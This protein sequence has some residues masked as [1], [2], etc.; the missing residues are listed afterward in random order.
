M[1]HNLIRILPEKVAS[2]IAAGEVVERPASVLKELIDNS[3]DAR[4]DRITIRIETGGKKLIRVT[5]NGSGMSRDDLLLCVERHATS[6]ITALADLSSVS[7]LGFRGE[8]LPSLAAVSRMEI[9]TR[10]SD[11]LVAYRLNIV[12]GKLNSIDETGAPPGT[13]VSVR[14]LFFNIPAR[15]KFLRTIQTE[16]DRIVDT[17]ARV[18]LPFLGIYFKADQS[19]KTLMNLPNTENQRDRLVVLFGRPVASAMLET[20][21]ESNGFRAKAYLAPP[22]LTRSRGDRLFCYVNQRPIRDKLLIAAIM[23]GYGQRLMRGN[24]PQVVLLL[25]MDPALVDINVHPTKQ[26][27]R[28]HQARPLY[29][30]ISA[31]IARA[32]GEP[33]RAVPSAEPY[34]SGGPAEMKGSAPMLGEPAWNRGGW[35][36]SSDEAWAPNAPS[37]ARLFEDRPEVIGQL[38]R[39]Y[40]LCQNA[41]GL[42]LIDQHAAHERIVFESLKK[43]YESRRIER[44]AFL[45][46][47]KLELSVK[48]GRILAT[49]LDELAELGLEIEPFGGST[50][51]IRSAPSCLSQAEWEALLNEVIALLQEESQLTSA[52]GVEEVLTIMACHGALRAGQAL[53]RT[54]MVSLL[55]QLEEMNLPTHCPHGRP[56]LKK[57]SDYDL[58]RMFK[59]AM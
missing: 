10:P 47:P 5:D 49:K 12:G 13:T 59:R 45:I 54:E 30:G 6:K 29:Q 7:S 2:Q 11:Q 19:G 23:Q 50:F 32:F 46:P 20:E 53:S 21:L 58:E 42:L 37:E 31:M 17:L 38:K 51:L 41:E 16:T 24:Y 33:L 15:R 35:S 18:A 1:M 36:G 56:I 26:E 39:T 25:D 27:V 9:T 14:D 3:I 40:L 57:F 28:F 4:A 55:N 44:Q 43:S 8:A 34:P 48:D 52:K 22:D